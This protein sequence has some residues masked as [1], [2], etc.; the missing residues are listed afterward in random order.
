M[1]VV[2]GVCVRFLSQGA[3]GVRSTQN[4]GMCKVYVAYTLGG[5]L[6]AA[7]C[8][9]VRWYRILRMADVVLFLCDFGSLL[10]PNWSL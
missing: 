3:A 4:P 5:G 6:V 1:S 7:I 9:S 2:F 10:G 8:V